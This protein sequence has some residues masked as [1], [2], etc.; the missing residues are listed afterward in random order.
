MNIDNK[1]N[2]LI[3]E[4]EKQKEK[5]PSYFKRRINYMIDNYNNNQY[6]ELY[7][8]NKW[9]NKPFVQIIKQDIN[10]WSILNHNSLKVFYYNNY[11]K[12]KNKRKR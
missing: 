3:I 9:L 12:S 1:N 5:I 6:K 2:N 10:F 11:F 7:Y 8:V 4:D